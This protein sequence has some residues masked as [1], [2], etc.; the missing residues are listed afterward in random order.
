MKLMIASDLHGSAYY[1]NLLK[2]L[3]VAEKADRLILLGDL[4]YHG[5]RND[6]PLEYNPKA[7]LSILNE[8]KMDVLC[9]RGNCDAEVD[10]MV[11]DFPI[12]ADYAALFLEERL[13]FVTHGHLYNEQHLPPLKKGDVFLQGH[14]HLPAIEQR[15]SYVFLNPGSIAMPKGGHPNTYMI[16][17]NGQFDLKNCDRQI[18]Q[19]LRLK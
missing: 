9:V 3:F 10:Q 15:Q 18:L 14:T 4:L 12:L 5:P 19:S 2:E 6:L 13:V 1:A 11:L 7:V 8:M 17:E 16:Y